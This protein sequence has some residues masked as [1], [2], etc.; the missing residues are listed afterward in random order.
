M[1][2][3]AQASNCY[4]QSTYQFTKFEVSIATHYEDMKDD[5]KCQ[6]WGGLGLG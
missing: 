1:P 4:R 6:K 2:Y 3:H 5:T